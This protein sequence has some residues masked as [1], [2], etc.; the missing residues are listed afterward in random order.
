[1]SESIGT[2][3]TQLWEKMRDKPYRDTFVEAHL[4]TNIADQLQTIREQPGWTKKQLAQ[5][6]GMSTSRITV[7][8]D[9]SY[10]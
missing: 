1:M 3:R 4:S 7:M 10:E 6:A 9:P 8:V 2:I 5:K